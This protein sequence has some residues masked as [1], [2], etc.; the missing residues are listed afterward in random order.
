MGRSLLARLNCCWL[1]VWW[2]VCNMLFGSL[3][4]QLKKNQVTKNLKG[5][6]ARGIWGLSE[7]NTIII[8]ELL[9]SQ[10]V[11]CWRKWLLHVPGLLPRKSPTLSLLAILLE[12]EDPEMVGPHNGKPDSWGQ[13]PKRVMDSH[14]SE[15]WTVLGWPPKMTGFTCYCSSQQD[16]SD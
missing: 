9:S 7:A 4:P 2:A 13:L 12:G 14:R 3:L 5:W 10:L 16:Y 11:A 15:D 1:A 6:E 8:F